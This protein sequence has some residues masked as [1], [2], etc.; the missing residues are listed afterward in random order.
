MKWL[1]PILG[2]FLGAGGGIGVG[3]M[4]LSPLEETQVTEQDEPEPPEDTS[5]LELVSLNNQFVVPVVEENAVQSMVILTLG[6]EVVEGTSDVIYTREAKLRD[7]F[8]RT[9]FGHANLGG[10]SG[11]FTALSNL[12]MLRTSLLTAARAEI[13][14]DVQNILITSLAR[15]DV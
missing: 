12:E 7:V 5:P 8:L 2:L 6:L 11:D 3:V 4:L 13:G 10:F 15:Q 1:L 9:L 14:P